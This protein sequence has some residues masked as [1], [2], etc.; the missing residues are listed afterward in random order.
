MSQAPLHVLYVDYD[1]VV[2]PDSVN[3]TRNG[4][5]L[6]HRAGHVLFENEPLLEAA[7][8]PYPNVRIVLW[9]SWQLIEGGYERAKTK[10]SPGL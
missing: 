2:H 9:P 3:R 10:L 5:E 7:L 6:L 1:G 4:I 8:A